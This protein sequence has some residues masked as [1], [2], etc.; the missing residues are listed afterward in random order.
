MQTDRHTHTHEMGVSCTN[1]LKIPRVIFLKNQ[2][3]HERGW[4]RPG[5]KHG[6]GAWRR[7]GCGGND[8]T[9]GLLTCRVGMHLKKYGLELAFKDAALKLSFW[10]LYS[11]NTHLWPERKPKSFLRDYRCL[12]KAVRF[13]HSPDFL[14]YWNSSSFCGWQCWHHRQHRAWTWR[15]PLRA[16]SL[17]PTPSPW[18]YHLCSRTVVWVCVFQ[19]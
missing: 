6:R 9:V 13:P 15:S 3:V 4:K 1:P 16:Q 2:C 17:P 7:E 10:A 5:W 18:V 11:V 19:K 12:W 14:L 8:Q